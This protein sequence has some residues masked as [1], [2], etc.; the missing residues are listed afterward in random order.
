MSQQASLVPGGFTPG[1]SNSPKKRSRFHDEPR[2]QRATPK[3][4]R[5]DLRTMKLRTERYR[6]FMSHAFDLSV[7]GVGVNWCPASQKACDFFGKVRRGRRSRDGSPLGKLGTHVDAIEC[8][9]DGLAA[10]KFRTSCR[11][12]CKKTFSKNL[13]IFCE[14]NWS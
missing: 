8:T 4:V 14:V 11:N 9:D 3:T 5:L 13:P 1:I 6:R 2:P 7:A 12:R 10:S